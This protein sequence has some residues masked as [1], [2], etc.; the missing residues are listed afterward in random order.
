MKTNISVSPNP[1][2]KR[3]RRTKPASQAW[4]VVVLGFLLNVG[5][6]H[7]PA[8]ARVFDLKN[9]T[10]AAYFGGTFGVS[11]LGD[12]AFG[13]SG[14]NGVTTDQAVRANYG[15][16]FG[17]AL[18]SFRGG[19]RLG[20]E[21]IMGRT[22]T[23][24]NGTS[25]GVS[26]YALDSKV[27]AFIPMAAAEAPIWKTPE[28][29]LSIGGGLG[30]AFVSLNQEYRMTSAGTSALGVSDYIEKASNQALAWKLFV[31]GET[32]FVDTTTIC[33]EVGYRSVKVGSL[34]STKDTT[35]ISGAQTVGSDLKNMD[36]SNRAFDLGG[37][38]G[39]LL[40][41]FYL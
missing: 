17:L 26:Y 7:S 4:L 20:L 27:S 34:Q 5:L 1:K 36:G 12:Y 25:G 30:Y 28:S 41:R 6:I 18:T 32:T 23:G 22:L 11:N 15:G 35:A 29:R 2:P 33:L 21:Y 40:F 37:A 9:E 38:Y 3:P 19:I 16:E 24:V 10:F 31:S 14:G 39:S 8:E 13:Q